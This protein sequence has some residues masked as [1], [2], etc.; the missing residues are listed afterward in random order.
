MTPDSCNM[1]VLAKTSLLCHVGLKAPAGY[2][3]GKTVCITHN[4]QNKNVLTNMRLRIE[5]L[6]AYIRS[7]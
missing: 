6:S 1:Q 2:D 7:H 5:T 3:A 4:E